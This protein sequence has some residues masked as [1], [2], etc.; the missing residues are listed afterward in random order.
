MICIG[1]FGDFYEDV[2]EVIVVNGMFLICCIFVV[3]LF[4][5]VV[6]SCVIY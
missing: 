1:N 6:V 3:G 4:L 2:F 5:V